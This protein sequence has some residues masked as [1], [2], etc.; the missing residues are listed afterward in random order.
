M[1]RDTLA[2]SALITAKG[3]RILNDQG[4]QT[5]LDTFLLDRTGSMLRIKAETIGGFM[6]NGELGRCAVLGAGE[7]CR[8]RSA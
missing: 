2:S 3:N 5:T 1:G 7:A 4:E 8:R 6:P